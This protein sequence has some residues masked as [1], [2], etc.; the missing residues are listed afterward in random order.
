MSEDKAVTSEDKGVDVPAQRSAGSGA[1]AEDAAS[2][3]V[4]LLQEQV[5][6]QRRHL[7][8][9]LQVE[10]HPAGAHPLVQAEVGGLRLHPLHQGR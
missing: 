10:D 3:E 8:A 5:L 2:R 6:H 9:V 4:L 1:A 7:R